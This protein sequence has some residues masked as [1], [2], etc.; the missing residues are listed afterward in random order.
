LSVCIPD[1]T[2]EKM[3]KVATVD[4]R[5][6]QGR[7]TAGIGKINSRFAMFSPEYFASRRKQFFEFGLPSVM[8]SYRNARDKNT[9]ALA[10]QGH[11][12]PGGVTS[13]AALD[14][15][16]AALRAMSGG[17]QDLMGRAFDFANRE[18]GAIE[19][20]RSGLVSE[21][22]ASNGAEPNF[23]AADLAG[24]AYSDSPS[25]AAPMALFANL[26]GIGADTI[27]P[28]TDWRKLTAGLQ[29]SPKSA[30]TVRLVS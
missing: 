1:N 4:E 13:S 29:L 10:R 9:F 25:S 27:N 26:T 21:L 7:V 8:E 30:S 22:R 18:R 28:P 12:A 16:A 17:R 23:A 20:A 14:R 2:A 5:A 6:R 11:I 3:A 15:M 19:G 24:R